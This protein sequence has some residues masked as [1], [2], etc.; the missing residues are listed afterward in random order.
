M[1]FSENRMIML[2]SVLCPDGQ[3]VL[4]KLITYLLHQINESKSESF[5]TMLLVLIINSSNENVLKK[6]TMFVMEKF[7]EDN[8]FDTHVISG[9]LIDSYNCMT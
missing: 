4:L 7:L 3:V 6:F 5:T 2:Q 1:R 9:I 8:A